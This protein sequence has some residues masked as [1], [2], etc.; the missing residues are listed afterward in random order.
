[1]YK[2]GYVESEQ[3]ARQALA[4][5]ID[6]ATQLGNQ[7]FD[8]FQAK[9]REKTGSQLEDLLKELDE[10]SVSEIMNGIKKCL[11]EKNFDLILA[12]DRLE[13]A[14][15]EAI[16]F[17]NHDKGMNVFGV[18]L[19]RHPINLQ[20]EVFVSNVT[21]PPE[22]V[23]QQLP[24]KPRIT[25]VEFTYNYKEKG[26]LPEVTKITEVFKTAERE[27]AGVHIYFTPETVCLYLGDGGIQVSAR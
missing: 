18:E 12:M 22:M 16:I 1:M 23:P 24:R 26:L 20:E 8:D 2:E 27:Y 25:F 10:E 4:Q 6:C 5:L 14:L 15:K 17:L 11:Q 19:H 21:P 3:R 7:Q 9:I 13:P